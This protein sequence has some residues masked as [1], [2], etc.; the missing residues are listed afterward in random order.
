MKKE[1]VLTDLQRKF[2]EHLFGE[3]AGDP[4]K[5]KRLAGY[6]DTVSGKEIME[7]LRDEILKI[8]QDILLYHAPKAS[9]AIVN[10]M[11][12]PIENG[13]LVKLKAAGEVL[14]RAGI[15]A[16]KDAGDARF[17]VPKGGL[18]ILPAKEATNAVP[19]TDTED[20]ET[21]DDG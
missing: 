4:N 2:L 21:N 17:K 14:N 13:V 20:E 3:A 16:P 7:A 11:D 6:A 8:S 12:N 1:R 15:V 19:D 10:A 9:M 18:F 5:A